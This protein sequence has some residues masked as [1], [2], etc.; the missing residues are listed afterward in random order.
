MDIWN[1]WTALMTGL[2]IG[3][4]IGMVLTAMLTISSRDESSQPES[5]EKKAERL[6]VRT[7]CDEDAATPPA[8]ADSP[9][10]SQISAHFH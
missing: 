5:K 1:V 3:V 6:D 9:K 10:E 4:F 7:H 2:F 8:C